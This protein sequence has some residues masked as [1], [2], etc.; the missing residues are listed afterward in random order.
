MKIS[1]D[2]TADAGY[3]KISK[4]KIDRTTPVSEYCN[5]DLDTQGAVVGIELLFISQ[6]AGD[7]KSWI[8]LVSAAE[9]L[10]KSPLTIRRWIKKGE[11]P[12]YKIGKEYLFVKEELDEYIKKQKTG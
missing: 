10:N 8:N 5:V 4:K 11:L 3:I 1:F 9:Y 2:R 12:S 7:F 6:Y